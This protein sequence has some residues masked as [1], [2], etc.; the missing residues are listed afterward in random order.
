MKITSNIPNINLI[1]SK[2]MVPKSLFLKSLPKLSPLNTFLISFDSQTLVTVL[3][4]NFICNLL[5]VEF[6]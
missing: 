2:S 1:I 3:L 5:T 6:A 4:V